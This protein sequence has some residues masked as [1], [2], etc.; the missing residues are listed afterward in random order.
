MIAHRGK[1]ARVRIDV[2]PAACSAVNRPE[3]RIV[4]RDAPVAAWNKE[5]AEIPGQA[6]RPQT[7]LDEIRLLLI[8][9]SERKRAVFIFG[10]SVY[11]YSSRDK[12]MNSVE[13][14]LLHEFVKSG[15]ERFRSQSET[16]KQTQNV[17]Q[18][19]GRDRVLLQIV[20]QMVSQHPPPGSRG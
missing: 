20:K 10:G 8:I 16:E 4:V 11:L 14:L 9:E 5:L 7:T 1:S 3:I 19:E 12:R 2:L 15:N 13:D 17:H 6:N 18:H